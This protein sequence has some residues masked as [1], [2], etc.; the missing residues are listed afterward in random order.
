MARNKY[1]SEF[2]IRILD[3]WRAGLSRHQLSAKYSIN[4]SIISRLIK[5]FLQTGRTSP[6]HSGGRPRETSRHEDSLIKRTI[7]NDPTASSSHIRSRLD[8]KISERTIR[9][10]AVEA[11]LFSRRPAKKPFI[12]SKNKK[13]RL[14]FAKAH[15]NW[16]VQKWRTVLFSD[17]SKFNLKDSDGIRRVR[18][19]NGQR[20]NP[21]YCKGTVKHGGGNI[22][23]WGCFS[24]QGI[25]PIHKIDGIMDRFMYRDILKDVMLPYAEEEMPLKWTFQQD[26]DPKHTSKVVK[27]WFQNNLIEVL[28]WPAQSPDLNPIENLWEIVNLK[29]NRENC[30]T[31]ENL[32]EAV[33]IAWEAISPDIINNL[34]SSMPKRCACVIQNKGFATKY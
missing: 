9:R 31:K 21:K 25:G 29:I 23:V 26:N 2:K 5:K 15:L 20:L 8:L 4:R 19:P 18:R 14:E 13:A 11:G 30:K 27:E 17:E 24:G 33:K 7:Q 6:T 22:M 3:D 1:S 10:R 28:R 12:S 16:S 34:I 32:F